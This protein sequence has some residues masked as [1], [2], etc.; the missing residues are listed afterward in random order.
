MSL[1]DQ[2]STRAEQKSEFNSTHWSRV[3]LAAQANSPEGDSAL[4]E[5]CRVYWQPLYFF[6]RRQGQNPEDAQD[7]VQGFFARLLEKKYLKDA[8]REKGKFRSFL[9]VAFKRFMADERDRANRLK[10]GGGQPTLSL[11]AGS[12]ESCYVTE[13]ADQMTPERIFDQRWAMA[14]LE[15]IRTRLKGEFTADGKARVFEELRVFLSGEKVETSYAEVGQRLGLGESNVKVTVHRLRQRYRELLRE[16]IGK[17]V[18]SP[19]A[20]NEE[21][22]AL[23]SALA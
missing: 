17:T 5:L 2:R 20:V 4:A 8:D 19:E 13:P 3:V 22:K 10:R 21:I 11:D 6:V 7:L 23:F 18:A 9:L 15:Q 1:T 14:L 12:A 16:E